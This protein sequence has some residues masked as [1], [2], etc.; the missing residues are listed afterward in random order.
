M[1]GL[2]ACGTVDVD[3]EIYVCD[4]DKFCCGDV[5]WMIFGGSDDVE[6]TEPEPLM[7]SPYVV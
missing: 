1:L 3:A 7:S 2:D 5:A 6:C 4:G